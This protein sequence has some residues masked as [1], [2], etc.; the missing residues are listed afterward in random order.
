M[1]D[2]IVVDGTGDVTF[3]GNHATKW[4]SIIELG[5]FMKGDTGN[6]IASIIRTLT[7]G[8]VD[9]YTIT[10]TDGSTTTFQVTNG[11]GSG[12]MRQYVYDPEYIVSAFPS[13]IPGYAEANF[14]A[15]VD[16]NIGKTQ[17]EINQ[18]IIGSSLTTA[19]TASSTLIHAQVTTTVTLTATANM[20][21]T[22]ITI[23]KGG[24]VL[25]TD[26]NV[27]ILT[28][29]DSVTANH[30]IST[31]YTAEFVIGGTTYTKSC[32]VKA[33]NPIYYGILPSPWICDVTDLTAVWQASPKGSYAIPGATD[34]QWKVCFVIP[35]SMTIDRAKVTFGGWQFP[36]DEPDNVTI[37][38]ES[39]KY[40]KSSNIYDDTTFDNPI[41]IA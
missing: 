13:G 22:S 2:I 10:F 29:Q 30:N 20:D 8:N 5:Q 32:T 24:T 14:A 35:S 7:E 36:L 38:G 9:T 34:G 23:K 26:E 41:I 4:R 18:L 17:E 3:P 19:L 31:V 37:G 16:P 21:A 12:D 39:Y 6:G 11:G 15:K 27:R 40:Y 1:D 28:C 33:Y 25:N